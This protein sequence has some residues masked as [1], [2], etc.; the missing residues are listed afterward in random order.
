MTPYVG[1]LVWRIR[2]RNGETSLCLCRRMEKK[3]AA[4][5]HRARFMQTYSSGRERNSKVPL[6]AAG[7]PRNRSLGFS[8]GIAVKQFGPSAVN[9][10]SAPMRLSEG[11]GR[12]LACNGPNRRRGVKPGD[13]GF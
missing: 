10:R 8:R 12:Y 1:G 9:P 4:T 2:E 7:T 6:P 11:Q 13:A 5:E 3:T